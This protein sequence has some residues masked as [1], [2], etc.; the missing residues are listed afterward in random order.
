MP[1]RNPKVRRRLAAGKLRLRI[2]DLRNLGPQAERMLVEQD[3]PILPIC[4]YVTVYMFDPARLDGIS[5][6]PRLEQYLGRI[7][8]VPAR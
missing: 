4:H 2:C 1:E 3:M 8:R 7:A 5:R 6:D